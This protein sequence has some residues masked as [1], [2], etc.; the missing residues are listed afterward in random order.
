M[1]GS[2]LGRG[3]RALKPVKL[4]LELAGTGIECPSCYKV[5]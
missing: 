3:G 2:S 5:G 4:T 1:E